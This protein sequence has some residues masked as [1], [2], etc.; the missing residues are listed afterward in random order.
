MLTGNEGCIVKND[1]LQLLRQRALMTYWH[2]SS[3]TEH[4]GRLSKPPFTSS[5]HWLVYMDTLKNRAYF[6]TAVRTRNSQVVSIRMLIAA[7]NR[8]ACWWSSAVFVH[9]GIDSSSV[10]VVLLCGIY[11]R[12]RHA[13][14]SVGFIDAILCKTV[15]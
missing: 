3:P 9:A 15:R 8:G 1:G 4:R 5:D 7:C 6:S 2:I 11:L 10:I 12:S 14:V 13:I